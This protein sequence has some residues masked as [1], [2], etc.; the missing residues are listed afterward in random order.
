M[1]GPVE[2]IGATRAI[3]VCALLDSFGGQLDAQPGATISGI[4]RS[5]RLGMLEVS[6]GREGVVVLV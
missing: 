2:I 5:S 3:E 6:D 1:L 4:V